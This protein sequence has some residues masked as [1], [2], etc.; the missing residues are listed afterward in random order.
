M[1]QS[2][3]DIAPGVPRILAVED[4]ALIVLLWP[5]RSGGG[6]I[7]WKAASNKSARI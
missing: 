4:E 1:P 5:K 3:V 6:V 2:G 7:T